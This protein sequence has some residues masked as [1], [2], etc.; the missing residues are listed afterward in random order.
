MRTASRLIVVSNRLP[1]TATCSGELQHSSGGLVAALEPLMEAIPSTWIGWTGGVHTTSVE[2][3]FARLEHSYRLVP[4]YLSD[5]EKQK[6]YLGYT[7]QVLWPLFHSLQSL[8]NFDETFW[9]AYQSVNEKFADAVTA[10]ANAGDLVW[11]HDYHLM[12]LGKSLQRRKLGV[13]LAYFH[14]IPFPAQDVFNVLPSGETILRALLSFDRIGFQTTHD[15]LNFIRCVRSRFGNRLRIRREGA[16]LAVLFEGRRTTVV[17]AP[18]GVDFQRIA[19]MAES[20][21]VVDRTKTI[22]T[23]LSG[24]QIM[25]GVDRLDYTKGLPQ[26]IAAYRTLLERHPG[27]HGKVA[28]LQLIV[29]SREEIPEYETLKLRIEQQISEINGHFGRPGWTPIVYMHRSVPCE[30]LLALYR[31]ASVMLVTSVRDGM[32]L[33]AKEYCSSRPD[34]LGVLVL[35]KFAGVAEELRNGAVLVNPHDVTEMATA[36]L[37]ALSM[38]SAEVR[39]RMWSMQRIVMHNDVWHWFSAAIGK[40]LVASKAALIPQLVAEAGRVAVA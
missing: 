24:I 38:E 8:C 23:A 10:T 22:E 5:F 2:S 16:E 9:S 4:V 15:R 33:V 7:N 29:P 1:V 30:E 13:Q 31:C 18:I 12:L 17:A 34:K 11:I 19:S 35:S 26:R 36:Y 40:N 6:Y 3:I 14:H 32:N 27:L 25:L 39:S 37:R 28:L 20:S 21:Q